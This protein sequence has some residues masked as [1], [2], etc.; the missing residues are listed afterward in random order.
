MKQFA[1]IFISTF[2]LMMALFARGTV[3]YD[4]TSTDTGTILIC[5]NNQPVGDQITLGNTTA[6]YLTN[7]S[8]EYYSS[9][10]AFAGSVQAD[11]SFY[12][13]NGALLSR[14]STT[15]MP[16]TIFYD[17]GW[18]GIEPP[19][20]YPYIH[21]NSAVLNFSAANLLTTNTGA[22]LPLNP[23]NQLPAN[24]TVVVTFQGL[25]GSD[26]VALNIFNPATVGSNPGLY[27]LNNSGTWSLLT[28][29]TTVAFGMRLQGSAQ[30]TAAPPPMI[31]SMGLTNQIVTVTWS[32]V[33]GAIYGLQSNTDLTGTNWVNVGSSLTAT[34]STTSQTNFIGNVPQQ[35]YRVLLQNP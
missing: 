4:D 27:W 35:F 10:S 9:N 15:R 16:G 34:G 26:Q 29:T 20:S 3:I 2:V 28:N 24:F 32:S 6:P 17:S 12:L 11:V 30:P 21:T 33:A 8:I 18:F 5:T 22:V 25:A 31:L 23:T 13:N 7:F 1:I 14:T 19:L